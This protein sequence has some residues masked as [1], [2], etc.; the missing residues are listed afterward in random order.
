VE[1]GTKRPIIDGVGWVVGIPRKV[2]LWDQRA[3]NHAVSE[4]TVGEVAGYLH[5]RGVKD[6]K[7]RVNQYAPLQEW[8]RLTQNKNVGAGWRYTLGTLSC[9]EYT[10]LPGRIFGGDNYNPYTNSVYL[11]SDMPAMGLAE[12]AY[13]KDVQ[14]RKYPGTYAAVQSLPLVSMYHETLATG[15]VMEYVAIRGSAE[16][17]EKIRRDLYARYG[18][19]LGGEFGRVLPD[20]STLFPIVGAIGGHGVATYKDKHPA[21]KSDEVPVQEASY[22]KPTRGNLRR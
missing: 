3:D 5:E 21:A 15:E 11:Y 12:S 20:G 22:Q 17:Q 4:E 14:N 10:L 6:V 16:E 1:Y 18:M 19:E 13:A 9:L 2:L 7:V 8:K